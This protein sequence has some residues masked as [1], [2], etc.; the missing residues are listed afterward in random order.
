MPS[1][2]EGP[3]R[4]QQRVAV[5]QVIEGPANAKNE[6]ELIPN[7]VATRWASIYPGRVQVVTQGGEVQAYRFS[8][9][10]LAYSS[11]IAD[12]TAVN[13]YLI[14]RGRELDVM[15]VLNLSELNREIELEVR[16]RI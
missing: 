16:E 4:K 13:W 12:I 8:R 3:G 11:E 1:P 6:K 9:V 10:R 2:W 7:T 15:S 14:F 5:V